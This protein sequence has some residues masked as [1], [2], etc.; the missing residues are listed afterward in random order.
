MCVGFADSDLSPA[1]GCRL[2]A[3]AASLGG[4]WVG[5]LAGSV[6][7]KALEMTCNGGGGT[8]GEQTQHYTN[9]HMYVRTYVHT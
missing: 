9:E 2:V 5:L 6:A 3:G 8:K 4:D 1:E 7:V